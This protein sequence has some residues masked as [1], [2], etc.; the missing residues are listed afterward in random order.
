MRVVKLAVPLLHWRLAALRR[1]EILRL[2]GVDADRVRYAIGN[3]PVYGA[4]QRSG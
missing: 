2:A 1:R 3:I 4:A